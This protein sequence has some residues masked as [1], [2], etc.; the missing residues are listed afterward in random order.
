MIVEASYATER[1]DGVAGAEAQGIGRLA[2]N[3]LL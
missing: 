2:P 3:T 1:E